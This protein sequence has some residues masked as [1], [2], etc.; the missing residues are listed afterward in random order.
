MNKWG[1]FVAGLL[2]VSCAHSQK[3]EVTSLLPLSVDSVE[4]HRVDDSLIRIV[5]HN[6]ELQPLLE[7]ERIT[8][9][10]MRLAE[11]LHINSVI[12]EGELL[13]FKD[14]AGVFVES[15]K[16]NGSTVVFVLDYFFLDGGNSLIRC[17]VSVGNNKLGTL[18]C[19]YQ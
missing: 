6:M 3:G 14:T 19:K 2:C 13:R 12:V 5:R 18:D 8:P 16:L 1:I 10:A 11:A 4:R 15:V 9:P 17:G 7:I